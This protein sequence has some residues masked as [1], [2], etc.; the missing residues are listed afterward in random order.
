[1]TLAG[2]SVL[3]TGATSGVGWALAHTFAERGALVVAH[4]RDASRLAAVADATGGVALAA[5]LAAP[6]GAHRLVYGA[7]AAVTEAGGAPLSVVVHNAAVQG[8]YTF[9]NREPSDAARDAA[10][11]LVVDLVAPIQATALLLPTLREAARASRSPSAVVNVTSGLALAPK[12]TAAV[13]CGAKAGL[14]TFTKALR[15]QLEDEAA[16]GGAVVRAVEAMLPLVDT[17]MTAGRETRVAKISPERAA[18]EIVAGLER[19]DDEVRVA[20][21]AAFARLH[22][23]VPD[24]AE[25]MLRNG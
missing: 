22:R 23:W 10:V 2:R 16:A 9:S 17:P 4:G 18:A 19:G 11:E 12:K 8:T 3:V 25:R 14:R 15:Y 20:K 21:A 24:V 6:D 7:L 5:D 13:Y 1:M